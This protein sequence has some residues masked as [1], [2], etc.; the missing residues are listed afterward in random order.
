MIVVP[1]GEFMMGSL[2]TEANRY[3]D[4][5]PQHKVT[6]AS[7]FAVSSF[8]VTFDDWDACAGSPVHFIAH[9]SSRM[10]P[11]VI[12]LSRFLML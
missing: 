1:S 6:I 5:G 12:P 8:D 7:A 10:G 3:D 11:Q 9:T 4:E 2:E